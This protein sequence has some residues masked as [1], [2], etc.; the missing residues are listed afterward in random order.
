M[1]T[2]QFECLDDLDKLK[3]RIDKFSQHQRFYSIINQNCLEPETDHR[4]RYRDT[5]VKVFSA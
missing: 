3:T 4:S 1:Q 5:N 2:A